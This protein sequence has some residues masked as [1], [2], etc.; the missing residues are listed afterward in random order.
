MNFLVC[1]E[2]KKFQTS[3]ISPGR[4]PFCTRPVAASPP[5]KTENLRRPGSKF[6]PKLHRM[7]GML[8]ASLQWETTVK[9]LGSWP[10]KMK[11]LGFWGVYG[12]LVRCP[13]QLNSGWCFK[14]LGV[15]VMLQ[16]KKIWDLNQ[17][18]DVLQKKN[19]DALWCPPKSSW[20]P[21]TNG[22]AKSWRRNLRKFFPL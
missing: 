11:A 7:L 5:Q 12:Q 18:H 13:L 1:C 17:I 16:D 3:T 19:M 22:A 14:S 9:H 6:R 20:K 21:M 2:K 4:W 15:S 10:T 8:V